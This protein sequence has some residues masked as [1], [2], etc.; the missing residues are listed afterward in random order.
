MKK[1]YMK[2]QMKVVEIHMAQMLCASPVNSVGSNC[3][4][5]LG[6]G[7]SNDNARG[8]ESDDWDDDW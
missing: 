3:G 7:G 1:E 2:P 4:L 8:R 5:G 6:N